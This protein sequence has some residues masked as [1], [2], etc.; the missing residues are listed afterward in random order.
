MPP[1]IKEY[2]DAL[3]FTYREIGLKLGLSR[4]RVAQ[5]AHSPTREFR[6]EPALL[7]LARDRREAIDNLIRDMTAEGAQEMMC[8]TTFG[9]DHVAIT[10][11]IDNTTGDFMGAFRW[12]PGARPAEGMGILTFRPL[13]RIEPEACNDQE[14]GE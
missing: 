1:T 8:R 13:P 14:G 2:A 6:L 5:L 11:V 7:S 3:G 4:A 9:A 12:R 10:E